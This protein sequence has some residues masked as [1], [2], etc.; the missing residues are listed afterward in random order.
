M[1]VREYIRGYR[2]GFETVQC[3]LRLHES[4]CPGQFSSS[5]AG[6]NRIIDPILDSAMSLYLALSF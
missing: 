5:L 4:G 2:A 1:H 3:Y 6:R